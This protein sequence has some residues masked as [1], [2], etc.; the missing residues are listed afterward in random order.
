M[1][2]DLNAV[3]KPKHARRTPKR[4]ERGRVKPATYRRVFDRD[5]GKCVLCGTTRG[6]EA[7]HVRYRSRGGTGEEHNL[8]MVCGP[9]THSATCHAKAHSSKQ[10]RAQLEEYMRVLYPSKWG[11]HDETR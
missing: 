6:L 4:K 5:G 10:V 8:A 7:H 9:A 1:F 2:G 3:P 11:T